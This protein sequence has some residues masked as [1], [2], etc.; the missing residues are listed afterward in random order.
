ML[1]PREAGEMQGGV[2]AKGR[3]VAVRPFEGA[4]VLDLSISRGVRNESL[5]RVTQ[6]VRHL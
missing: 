5:H 2:T 1:V 4:Q 3:K 6:L